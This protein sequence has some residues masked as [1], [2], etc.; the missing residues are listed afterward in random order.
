MYSKEEIIRPFNFPGGE[1]G[2]LLIHGFTAS[3]VDLKPLGEK[4]RDWGY[5]VSAPLLPGHGMTHEQMKETAWGDWINEAHR[6]LK[7]MRGTC[8][9]ITAVGHSMG[10]L[11]ALALAAQQKTDGV[12][13][14]NAPIAYRDPELRKAYCLLDKHEYV[15]KPKRNSEISF[16][17]EGL[18][19]F[20][21]NKVPVRCLVSLNQAITAVTNELF[22]ITCPALI[23]QSLEDQTVHPDSGRII[24]Q[25]I[26]HTDKQV[27]YWEKEDHY[28]PL[29]PARDEVAERIGDFIQKYRIGKEENHALK[30]TSL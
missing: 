29:S 2:V 27:I 3:P 4:L 18:P 9:W 15:D 19:H 7:E 1:T 10:G 8:R 11:I 6:A 13:S 26:R 24:E 17:R 28:L 20:S 25:N 22:N 12:V 5:T 21:Y 30:G 23:I 14:I 16:N